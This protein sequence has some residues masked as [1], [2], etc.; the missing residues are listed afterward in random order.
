MNDDNKFSYNYTAPTK[1]ER[2]EIEDIRRR[3]ANNQK[4]ETSLT[5]LRKLDSKVK[6]PPMTAG[7][8]LGVIGVLI[9]GLGL[10]MV[11]E[12][13]ILV[14]GIAVMIVGCVPIALAYPIYNIIFK[15][16]KAKYGDEILR[17]SEELLN[18]SEPREN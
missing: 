5:K 10:T 8:T 15:K 9:F 1:N 17:I 7:I 3:Y 6:N 12:W 2:R 4:E 13:N 14:W 11:L 16:N 18:E